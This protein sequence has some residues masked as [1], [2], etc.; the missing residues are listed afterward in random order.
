MEINWLAVILAAVSAFILGGL[1]YGPLFGKK[2]MGYTGMTEEKAKS[3]N[4]AKTYGLAFL[5]ALIAALGFGLFLHDGMTLEQVVGAGLGVG[6]FWVTTSFGISYLF[7]QKPLG[8]WLVN[9]GYHVLQFAL[10]G[11]VF[12]LMS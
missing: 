9:S 6:L 4:P 5:L 10:Y 1:W 12:G 3:A 11:A 2:W 7:E 8:L